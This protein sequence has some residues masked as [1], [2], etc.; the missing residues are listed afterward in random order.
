MRKRVNGGRVALLPLPVMVS[1]VLIGALVLSGCSEGAERN[2]AAP[3]DLPRCEQV[4]GEQNVRDAVEGM[5]EGDLVVSS[6]LSVKKLAELLALEAKASDEE[7]L[8]HNSYSACRVSMAREKE[9][10]ARVVEATVKWSVLL[11]DFMSEP[12]YAETWR[13]VNEQV[14][15][16]TR[17]NGSGMRLLVACGLPGAVDG[18]LQGPLEMAVSDPGFDPALRG[19]LM[20]T[21]A[22]ALTDG[23]GCTNAPEIP[24]TL[25]D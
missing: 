20:T 14:F 17:G 23:L 4:L 8:L 19:K 11:L 24:L 9:G 2:G 6:R 18:Q 7:D 25:S 5:G 1:A 3:S 15:V 22:R 12:K 21:F 13:K 16:D 10:G